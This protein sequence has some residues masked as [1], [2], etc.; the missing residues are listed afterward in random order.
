MPLQMILS[1]G[2]V[3]R[4]DERVLKALCRSLRRLELLLGGV[5]TGEFIDTTLFGASLKFGH[6]VRIR[7]IFCDHHHH[8]WLGQL[9][10][11]LNLSDL[12]L[13]ALV[14]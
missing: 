14:I 6:E 11:I 2:Q 13:Q 3:P 4:L 9:K 12:L 8:Y 10:P 5:A 1:L 7:I